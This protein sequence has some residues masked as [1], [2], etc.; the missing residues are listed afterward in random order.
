MATKPVQTFSMNFVEAAVWEDEVGGKTRFRVTLTK[1]YRD[2]KGQ[3]KRTNTL[4]PQDIPYAVKVLDSAHTFEAEER[5][6]RALAK[7][8][9]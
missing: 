4:D 6:R 7:K 2:D 9:A 5:Q 8:T 1:R 3:W